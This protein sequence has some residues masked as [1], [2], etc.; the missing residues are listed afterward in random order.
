VTEDIRGVVE[1]VS[2]ES[3]A[4]SHCDHFLSSPAHLNDHLR[5]CHTF[6]CDHCPIVFA[7]EL[8]LI[9]HVLSC[10]KETMQERKV[11]EFACPECGKI[12][13][14]QSRLREHLTVHSKRFQCEFCRAKFSQPARLLRHQKTA[15]NVALTEAESP[16]QRHPLACRFCEKT[17][18]SPSHLQQHER[19]HTRER[20]FVC[21][22]CEKRFAAKH[23][24][25]V[26]ARIH[27]GN[28]QVY[29]CRFPPCQR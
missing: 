5:M 20:P 29:A 26:H 17:F 6:I 25:T 3:L 12:F 19:T 10:H 8:G 22:V 11:G 9:R 27:S 16:L 1:E 2:H 23:N 24:L 14:Y 21:D 18:V 13:P 7:K 28:S 15:H 4:C